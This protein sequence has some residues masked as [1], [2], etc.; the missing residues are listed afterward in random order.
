M[1][2]AFELGGW[3]YRLPSSPKS[4]ELAAIDTRSVG[5]F[6]GGARHSRAEGAG[7]NGKHAE[8]R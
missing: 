3:S 4:A 7:S 2:Y 8:A 5:A 1:R 6:G